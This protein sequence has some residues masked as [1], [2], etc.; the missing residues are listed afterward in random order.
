MLALSAAGVQGSCSERGVSYLPP[1]CDMQKL[2]LSKDLLKKTAQGQK[3]KQFDVGYRK[4]DPI[5]CRLMYAI[6]QA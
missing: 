5:T 3:P 1:M 2:G 6:V 4:T